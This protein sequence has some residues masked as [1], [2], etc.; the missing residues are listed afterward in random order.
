MSGLAD[1]QRRFLHALGDAES[2]FLPA[3]Q[4]GFDVYRN[5][6]LGAG[7]DALEANF[8]SVACLVG[9]DWFRAAAAA[10]VEMSPPEDPRLM[11]Y[12]DLFP[13]FL[14]AAE[15]AADVPY[16]GD[17]ARLDRLWTE[18]QNAADDILM[19]SAMWVELTEDGL[20]SVTVRPH[21]SLRLFRSPHPAV[22]IWRASREGRAVEGELAWQPEH[23][24]V[25]RAHMQVTVHDVG[26]PC[27]MFIEACASGSTLAEAAVHTHRFHP[28]AA[29]DRILAGCQLAG[30][31]VLA[32][33]E[34][35]P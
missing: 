1:Y 12:G 31:F 29:I 9:R 13:A 14:D 30:L 3:R 17:V 21:A 35:N 2:H 34:T 26:A 23:A 7:I 16:L 19:P 24:V 28:D 15:Q 25:V 6:T 32:H 22:T 18:S 8:P 5:T 33:G 11:F 4:A 20:S 27:L 10:Y